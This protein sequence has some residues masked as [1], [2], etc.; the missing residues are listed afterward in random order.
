MNQSLVCTSSCRLSVRNIMFESNQT[1]VVCH[2]LLGCLSI[3]Q[4]IHDEVGDFV[5]SLVE[6][7]YGNFVKRPLTA[8]NQFSKKSMISSYRSGMFL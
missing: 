2:S 6:S 1:W 4:V 7:R 8:R 5:I 3:A